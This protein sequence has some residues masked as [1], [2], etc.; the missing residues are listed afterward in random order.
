MSDDAA[1]RLGIVD[2][3]NMAP[4]V[5]G[6]PAS[7]QR[8]GVPARVAD[9]LATGEVDAAVVPAIELA[10]VPGL[11]ALPSWGIAADGPSGSVLLFSR[12]PLSDVRSVSLDASS[13]TSAALAQILLHREG[14]RELVLRRQSEGAL[15][16][17][18]TGCDA[19]LLIGDPALRATA[20]EGVT[21]FDL[22][23]EWKRHVGLPFV[24]AV[25]ASR[26]GRPLSDDERDLLERSAELGMERLPELARQEARRTSLPEQVLLRYLREQLRFRLD[27]RFLQGLRAFLD[28]AW[29]LGLVS[30]RPSPRFYEVRR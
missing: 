12:V 8:R 27:A 30:E 5:A 15:A 26:P 1:L 25:W 2:Y 9:W 13:R 23:A 4:L 19:A 22:A 7:T 21:A 29:R 6:L 28:E 20:P 10:C 11:V 24:F 16:E 14:V 17:R 18:L 3:A